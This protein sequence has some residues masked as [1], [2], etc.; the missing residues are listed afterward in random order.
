MNEDLVICDLRPEWRGK[1][2]IT[3][4]RPDD[5]GYAFPLSWAGSYAAAAVDAGGA[6]YR[7]QEGRSL[8]RFAVPRVAAERL[9][10]QPAPGVIDGD[11]GPV[12]SNTALNRKAL[13]AAAYSA[14]TAQKGEA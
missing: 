9:S 5:C 12:V 13:R 2:Y 1:P 10:Q 4:W 6:Y 3:F 14:A 7:K 8:I 11:A